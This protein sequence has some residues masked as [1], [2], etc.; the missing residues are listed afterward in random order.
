MPKATLPFGELRPDLALLDNQ[1]AN[2]ADNVFPF[3]NTYKP[4]PCLLPFSTAMLPAPCMGLGYARKKD[5]TWQIYAGTATKLY[6]WSYAG[7]GDITNTNV[8]QL[9][10]GSYAVPFGEKWIFQQFG[11]KVVATQIGNKSQWVDTETGG[12][13]ADL[14]GNPPIAHGCKVIGDFLFLYGLASDPVAG[15]TGRQCA[16]WCGINDITQWTIGTQLCDVQFFPDQGPVQGVAGSEVAGYIVQDRGI[17]SLQFL[18]G[19]INLIF[20][21]ARVVKERGSI[22]E[23]GYETNA[24]V[25]YFLAEDGYYALAGTQL[26]PI[27]FEKINDTFLANSDIGSR[28][29]VQCFV[30]AK[31]YVIWPFCSTSNFGNIP[32]YDRAML[33]N[34]ANQR[35]ATATVADVD[36]LVGAQA[37]AVLS[38]APLDLDTDDASDPND[39]DLDSNS[40]SLDS[41]KYLGG[42]PLVCAVNSRG[43]LCALNGPNLQATLETAE[44]HLVPGQRAFVSEVY[45]LVDGADTIVDVATRERLGDTPVWQG[46]AP[47]SEMPL[48][49]LPIEV[50]GSASILTSSRLHRFRVTVPFAEKWQNAQGVLAEAQPDGYA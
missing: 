32:L 49:G 42:R 45:P 40:D 27:G 10:S 17:R 29:I 7:W 39:P 16:M 28:N 19:D 9:P 13:F 30:A 33:Y 23:F 50:T 26:I 35:W 5:G 31:P 3:S 37:Y 4:V 43:Q 21:F 6:Q 15:Q 18:P 44:A 11:T 46:G 22:S 47:A 48:G 20:N 1:Y 25:L 12:V 24:D 36:G 34:W 8:A 14:P 41:F 2:V 38:T